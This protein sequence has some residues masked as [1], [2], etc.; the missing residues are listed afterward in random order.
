MNEDSDNDRDASSSKRF[1][2]RKPAV[3]SMKQ[4]IAAKSRDVAD[5]ED[6]LHTVKRRS[7]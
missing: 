3:A 2:S 7:F 6:G 5:P 4:R 1:S